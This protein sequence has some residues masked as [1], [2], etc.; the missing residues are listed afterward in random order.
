MSDDYISRSALIASFRNVAAGVGADSPWAIE[1]IVEM[2]DRAP[3]EPVA[4]EALFEQ[5]RSEAQMRVQQALDA[6]EE[7]LR[8]ECPM[9]GSKY[10]PP[11]PTQSGGK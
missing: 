10:F 9:C 3:A 5:M 2:I 4:S 1:A 7:L 11:R 6:E 8:A